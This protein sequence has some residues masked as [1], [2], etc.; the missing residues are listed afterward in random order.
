[1]SNKHALNNRAKQ[2]NPNNDAYYLA[3]GLAGRPDPHVAP[4]QVKPAEPRKPA[5]KAVR[6]T[7]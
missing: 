3:R 5:I 2:L 6:R 4:C 1:M 7:G